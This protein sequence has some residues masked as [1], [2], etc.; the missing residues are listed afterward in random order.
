MPAE[1]N[2]LIAQLQHREIF[3]EQLCIKSSSVTARVVCR[4]VPFQ[5]MSSGEI[6]VRAESLEVLNTCRK[7]PFELK[8]FVKAS[9]LLA[10]QAHFVHHF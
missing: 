2:H 6:E 8:D 10:K 9:C 4:V 3:S 1:H 7:L 5:N